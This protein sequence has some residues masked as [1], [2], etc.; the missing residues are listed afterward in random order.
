MQYVVLIVDYL[1]F[2]Y[3]VE[4]KVTLIIKAWWEMLGACLSFSFSETA[5]FCPKLHGEGPYYM[6]LIE[7]KPHLLHTFYKPDLL[8]ASLQKMFSVESLPCI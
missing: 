2:Q 5:I 7:L 1:F 8:L 3:C 6:K 4:Y